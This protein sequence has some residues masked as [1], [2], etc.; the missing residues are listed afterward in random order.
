MDTVID[1]RD[2]E[3]VFLYQVVDGA[4]D[5]SLGIKIARMVGFPQEVVEVGSKLFSYNL[6]ALNRFYLR[7]PSPL[8]V[9][10]KEST[11]E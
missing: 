3:L 11:R 6:I 7:M 1:E 9:N 5:K 2:G 10:W 8:C 4:A